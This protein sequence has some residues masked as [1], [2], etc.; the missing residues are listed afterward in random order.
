[1][2]RLEGLEDVGSRAESDHERPLGSLSRGPG[3]RFLEEPVALEGLLQV[4]E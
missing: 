1:M 2:E 3:F 4:T